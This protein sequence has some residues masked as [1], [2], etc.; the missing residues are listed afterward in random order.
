MI[1]S[2][3]LYEKGPNIILLLKSVTFLDNLVLLSFSGGFCNLLF[4][5]P[6]DFFS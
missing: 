2:F 6:A 1:I 5:P 3:F 4:E